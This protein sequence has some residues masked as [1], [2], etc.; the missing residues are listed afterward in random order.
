MKRLAGVGVLAGVLVVGVACSRDR[1]PTSSSD[2]GAP[3]WE[4]SKVEIGYRQIRYS[5]GPDRHID[6]GYDYN[7]AEIVVYI[8][9]VDRWEREKPGWARGRRGQIV[10][11]VKTT[12]DAKMKPKPIYEEY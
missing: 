7:R 8:P 2:P 1:A 10:G 5:D 4:A 3:G 6:F 11:E 9:T 12:C